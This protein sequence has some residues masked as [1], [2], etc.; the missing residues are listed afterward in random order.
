MPKFRVPIAILALNETGSA[1]H[2]AQ[3]TGSSIQVFSMKRLMPP[4]L[5]VKSSDFLDQ[6]R[7]QVWSF[8]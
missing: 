8:Q 5:R 6:R 7:G 2:I 1:L 4:L 3:A